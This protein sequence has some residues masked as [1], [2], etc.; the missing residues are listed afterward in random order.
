MEST[1]AVPP[2]PPSVPPT[3]PAPSAPPAP[4]LPPMRGGHGVALRISRRLLWVGEAAYPLHNIA[5]VHTFTLRPDRWGA[6]MSF[7]KWLFGSAVVL[8]L[9]QITSA[10]SS[11]YAERNANADGLWALGIGVAVVLVVSLCVRLAAPSQYVLGVETSGPSTALVTLPEKEQLRQLVGLIVHAIEH[12]EAEFSVRVERLSINP[13]N[14]H[15]GDSVN[16]YG[17]AGHTGVSK[18]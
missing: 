13:K 8:V 15:F 10:G 12:P 6:F 17:G 3:P 1:P 2:P 7:L 11:S 16:I 5:R 18:S 14:Y 4:P 9:L